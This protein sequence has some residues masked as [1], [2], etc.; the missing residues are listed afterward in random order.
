MNDSSNGRAR[1]QTIATQVS[2]GV[3]VQR[4]V[5]DILGWFGWQKR[6]TSA[7]KEVR[8]ALDENGLL[9]DPDLDSAIDLDAYVE[10]HLTDD[11]DEHPWPRE[12]DE[13]AH[14][15]SVGS[16]PRRV[17]VRELLGW[18]GAQRR[19]QVVVQ[20]VR[21]ALVGAGLRTDPDFESAYIDAE[22]QLER[23][24]PVQSSTTPGA[25][26][27]HEDADEPP[28]VATAGDSA[29]GGTAVPLA[30]VGGAVED[31][32]LRV[33]AMRSA[34][35]EAVQLQ[36]Y[37]VAPTEPLANA[38]TKMILRDFSQLPVM[39]DDRT[40]KG[41]ITWR[42]IGQHL[43]LKDGWRD[44]PVKDFIVPHKEVA[45]DTSLLA[46][47]PEIVAHEY[48]LVRGSDQTV[49]GIVTT[50]DLALQFREQTEP[51]LLLG[52][53]ENQIRRLIAG[54]FTVAEL[55][56]A[57]HEGDLD[58]DVGDVNDM[59]FGEYLRLLQRPEHWDRLKLPIDR[60][61]FIACLDEVRG[62]RNEVMHFDPGAQRPEQ[63]ETLRRASR[64]LRELQ[65]T[66]AL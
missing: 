59:T 9:T 52:E 44:R 51:F 61:Q 58:R 45:H 42:S 50:M 49:T 37:K 11:D 14:A 63:L 6:T 48:V 66:G 20:R 29:A 27:E 21:E 24:P 10:F 47:I 62:V 5:R 43:G 18:F 26:L 7:L 46:A 33:G 17:T 15:L 16:G 55:R 40:V 3:S 8:A 54:K 35:L 36:L 22:I 64:F 2:A 41:V 4:T 57:S 32:V 28:S 1:I 23:L 56:A 34:N 38:I 53:I 39:S 31:A 30:V 19:G 60:R 12:L 65:V 13:V 25:E